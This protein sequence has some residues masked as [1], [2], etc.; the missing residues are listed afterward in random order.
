L[1][2][3]AD[4]FVIAAGFSSPELVVVSLIADGATLNFQ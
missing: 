4:A 2:S 3:W 1:W